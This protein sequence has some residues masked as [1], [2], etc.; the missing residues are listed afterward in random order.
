[1]S[2]QRKLLN[3]VFCK[4]MCKS[5]MNNLRGT[6]GKVVL[7]IVLLFIIYELFACGTP[8]VSNLAKQKNS[9]KSVSI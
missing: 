4:E 5:L 9:H 6:Q 8:P 7:T 1:M 2:I 3:T